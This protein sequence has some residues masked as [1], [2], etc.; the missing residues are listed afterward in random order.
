MNI[1]YLLYCFADNLFVLLLCDFLP[2][3]KGFYGCLHFIYSFLLDLLFLQK[4][5]GI[6]LVKKKKG[7]WALSWK[8]V[9]D[10]YLL[11]FGAV[12]L[13]PVMMTGL[14]CRG[15]QHLTRCQLAL[16]CRSNNS[17][18]WDG[19]KGWFPITHHSTRHLDHIKEWGKNT[20]WNVCLR[21]ELMY[22][23]FL[24]WTI[25]ML[26]VTQLELKQTTSSAPAPPTSILYQTC[27]M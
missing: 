25:T 18:G 20:Q 15:W 6:G 19:N 17:F 12:S 3:V 22:Y 5:E 2:L 16:G 9:G 10:G 13:S 14:S 4:T 11:F 21:R 7:G 26:I 1:V 8:T 24:F 27:V 23:V